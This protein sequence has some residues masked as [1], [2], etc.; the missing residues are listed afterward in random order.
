MDKN[1]E[2]DRN[3]FNVTLVQLEFVEN[4]FIP[5]FLKIFIYINFKTTE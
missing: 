5:F 2:E 3:K 1:F 4:N